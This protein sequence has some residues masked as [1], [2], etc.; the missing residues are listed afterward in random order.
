M[1][2]F[3]LMVDLLLPQSYFVA[4]SYAHSLWINNLKKMDA[5]VTGVV[6]RSV[7]PRFE[8]GSLRSF[9]VLTFCH[10]N[11]HMYLFFLIASRHEEEIQEHFPGGWDP[12]RDS[13]W[14]TWWKT[15]NLEIAAIP[16]GNISPFCPLVSLSHPSSAFD[17][18]LQAA[19]L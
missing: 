11:F 5:P 19:L 18:V 3:A 9:Q 16:R 7:N 10:H 17:P 13:S 6:F 2:H 1:S 15:Y 14:K 8:W 4:K 12:L